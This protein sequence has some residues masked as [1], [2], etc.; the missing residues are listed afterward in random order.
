MNVALSWA[1]SSLFQLD[2]NKIYVQGVQNFILGGKKKDFK[3]F[4]Y[5]FFS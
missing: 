4:I 1:Y 3:N 5:T 2:L